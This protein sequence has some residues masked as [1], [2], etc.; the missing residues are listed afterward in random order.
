MDA[1]PRRAARR[2]APAQAAGQAQGQQH[3]V[4]DLVSRSKS[5]K[6]RRCRCEEG[7]GVATAERAVHHYRAALREGAVDSLLAGLG[8][9][10]DPHAAEV[11]VAAHT[12]QPMSFAQLVRASRRRG[13]ARGARGEDQML[14]GHGER[15]AASSHLQRDVV[16]A[17]GDLSV[18]VAQEGAEEQEPSGCV[19]AEQEVAGPHLAHPHRAPALDVQRGGGR[20]AAVLEELADAPLMAAVLL[21]ALLFVLAMV[22]LLV[23]V[24]GIV[25]S[26]CRHAPGTMDT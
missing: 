19:A 8:H 17:C 24:L 18:E 11:A 7:V 4:R 3:A 14:G 5:M 12:A 2:G 20:E 26:G 23:V 9:G 15:G 21:L 16:R 1:F 6:P 22:P 10:I 13:R 25:E